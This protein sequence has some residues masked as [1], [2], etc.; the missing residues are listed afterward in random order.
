MVWPVATRVPRSTAMV[1]IRPATL[2]PI[3]TWSSAASVPVTVTARSSDASRA[4]CTATDTASFATPPAL[5]GAPLA[6]PDDAEPP[7]PATASSKLAPSRIRNETGVRRTHWR[8]ESDRGKRSA[9]IDPDKIT[10]DA[11][12]CLAVE[13]RMSL[14]PPPHVSNGAVGDRALPPTHHDGTI[15]PVCTPG[16]TST[17]TITSSRRPSLS[18]SRCRWGARTSTSSTRNPV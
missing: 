6:G 5:P 11:A 14:R 17:S 3:A 15:I 7:Q 4:A 13:G 2:K 9:D 10:T 16:T 1:S 18:S 8:T 12:G